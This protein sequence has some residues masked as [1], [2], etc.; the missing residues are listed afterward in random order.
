M[1][2]Y[3]VGLGIRYM[4][5]GMEMKQHIALFQVQNF[6]HCSINYSMC[7]RNSLLLLLGADLSVGSTTRRLPRLG[8]ALP[9][10]LQA[11]PNYGKDAPRPHNQPPVGAPSAPDRFTGSLEERL[12]ECWQPHTSLPWTQHCHHLLYLHPTNQHPFGNNIFLLDSC[13]LDYIQG[14]ILLLATVKS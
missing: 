5:W 2:N 4:L 13:I 11:A 3:S 14:I 7:Y 8:C 6:L 10:Q 1:T 12:P 9:F